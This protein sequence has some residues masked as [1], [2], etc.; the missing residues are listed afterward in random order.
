M[1]GSVISATDQDSS[2]A[3]E[4]VQKRTKRTSAASQAE[5]LSKLPDCFILLL[6]T[7]F[8]QFEVVRSYAADIYVYK[9]KTSNRLIQPAKHIL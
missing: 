2:S 5:R 9:P 3:L 6:L 7:P 8:S 4:R 1:R